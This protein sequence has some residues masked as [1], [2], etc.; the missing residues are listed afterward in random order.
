MEFLKY[1]LFFILGIISPFVLLILINTFYY[2]VIKKIKP[3][4]L[5]FKREK[6]IKLWYKLF[7]QFPRRFVLDKLT[8]NPNTFPY[9]GLWMVV[10]KQGKGKTITTT[11]LLQQLK[12]QYPKLQIK[13][14]FDYKHED[15]PLHHWKDM[16]FSSNGIY[17]EV[18]V[19]D[20]IQNWF[21]SM[22]SKNFPPEM[23]TEISQQRK[24]RKVIIGT[25]QLFTRIA[26]PIR[27]QTY[28]IFYPITLF[29][30]FTIVRVMEPQF[31]ESA[32]L[33]QQKLRKIFCFVQTEEIRDSF[34]TYK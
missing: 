23:L 17:G 13:T 32:N 26:K 7:I 27:E 31:D 4:P 25:S 28:L 10:G 3:I 19:L 21:N 15:K 16:V 2:R 33:I 18:D 6:P 29:G 24:Q 12:G 8:F 1:I 5:E 9:K 20:E 22:E 14:N 11:Y 30:C 34:D